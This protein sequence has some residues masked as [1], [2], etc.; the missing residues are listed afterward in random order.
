MASFRRTMTKTK[1]ILSSVAAVVWVVVAPER[2]QA[3]VRQARPAAQVVVAPA[4][5][6]ARPEVAAAARQRV[7]AHNAPA[8]PAAAVDR[9]VPP[10]ARGGWVAQVR[11]G[12]AR[13]ASVPAP[14]VR[15]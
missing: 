4:V 9:A 1:K 6:V 14:A 15:E 11:V 8:A 13:A 2:A 3:A 10:Q 5:L 12:S 7:S